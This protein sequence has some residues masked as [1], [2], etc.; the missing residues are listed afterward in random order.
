MVKTGRA[1]SILAPASHQSSVR[2]RKK[3]VNVLAPQK[4]ALQG[5]GANP[6]ISTSIPGM[7]RYFDTVSIIFSAMADDE[8][9]T[10][11]VPLGADSSPRMQSHSSTRSIAGYASENSKK[12]SGM[13]SAGGRRGRKILRWL[14]WLRN[15]CEFEY[16]W[17]CLQPFGI[18]RLCYLQSF[19]DLSTSF[20]FSYRVNLIGHILHHQHH[21]P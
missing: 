1:A 4:D 13:S 10:G 5:H 2:A 21:P 6:Q 3:R 7:L 11:S 9:T 14:G 12:K 20:N 8:A 18:V 17:R 16:F 15:D 19:E